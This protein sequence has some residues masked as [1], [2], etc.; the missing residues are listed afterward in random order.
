MSP[1]QILASFV[2]DTQVHAVALL[3]AADIVFGVL[4]AVK[5]HAFRVQNLVD[6]LHDDV[7]A[8][9]LPWFALFAFGK[10]SSSSVGGVDFGNVADVFFGGITLAIGASI[11]KS[12]ADLGVKG[13]PAVLAGASNPNKP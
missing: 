1:T 5:L 7:L 9:V 3:V 11:I 4:A 13:V 2:N 12:L 6:T 8:K 10:V